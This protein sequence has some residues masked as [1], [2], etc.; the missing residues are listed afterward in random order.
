M[1]PC[2][3]PEP[4]P[5]FIF[6]L[7]LAGAAGSVAD[8]W[9]G[10]LFHGG[11][12]SSVEDFSYDA[13]TG[14]GIGAA[15]GAALSLS[16]QFRF[17]LAAA[18]VFAF[19]GFGAMDTLS[20]ALFFFRPL[21]VSAGAMAYILILSAPPALSM[22]LAHEVFLRGRNDRPKALLALLYAAPGLISWA[23]AL[24]S[25]IYKAVGGEK[26]GVIFGVLQ[27]S[28]LLAALAV[29]RKIPRSISS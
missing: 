3:A 14:A 29:D 11:S 24:A 27:M 5:V 17:R 23:A 25:P 28:A 10:S 20:R 13:A 2:P 8:G 15:I 7:A 4:K 19:F 9:I 6:F 12:G 18:P 16:R 22:V 26:F 1:A 21:A